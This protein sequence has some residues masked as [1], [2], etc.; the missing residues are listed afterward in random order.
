MLRQM[1]SPVLDGD[2][3]AVLAYNPEDWRRLSK[4]TRSE[5]RRVAAEARW[6]KQAAGDLVIGKATNPKTGQRGWRILEPWAASAS[7][8]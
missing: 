1:A 4:Q 7:H 5:R 6:A 3:L 8:K 2:S